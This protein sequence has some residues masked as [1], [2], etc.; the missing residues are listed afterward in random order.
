VSSNPFGGSDPDSVR[1]SYLSDGNILLSQSSACSKGGMLI[2]HDNGVWHTIPV[3]SKGTITS[4]LDTS[5]TENGKAIHQ[6]VRSTF[7]FEN[8]GS[9]AVGS[10]TLNTV[11]LGSTSHYEVSVDGF[12]VCTE[13]PQPT[14]WDWA[15]AVGFFVGMRKSDGESFLTAYSL[16]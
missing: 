7:T 12:N 5:Y 16:K 8:S 9:L 14:K 10:S 13:D 1:I 3:E 15:P 2:G 6:I 11:R 4:L